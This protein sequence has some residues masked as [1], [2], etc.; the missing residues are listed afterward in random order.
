MNLRVESAQKKKGEMD[1]MDKE[2]SEQSLTTSV[3]KLSAAEVRRSQ[4]LEETKAKNAAEVA[5]VILD[6]CPAPAS[7]NPPWK[8]STLTVYRCAGEG[9]GGKEAAEPAGD[10]REAAGEALGGRGAPKP[11]AHGAEGARGSGGGAREAGCGDAS[12]EGGVGESP[13]PLPCRAAP[14]L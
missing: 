9:A 14:H 12:R 2:A 7:F 1:S 13:P 4:L 6:P 8:R 11:A 3:E 5:K 10:G